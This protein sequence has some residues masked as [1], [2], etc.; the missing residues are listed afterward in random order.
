M[1][2]VECSKR[3]TGPMSIIWCTA[4]VSGMSAPASRA[5]RG[6]QTPQQMTTR[7]ASIVAARGLHRMD[8]AVLDHDV[9]HLGVGK[10]RQ[11]GVLGALAHDRGRPQRVDHT[12][13]GGVEATD[14]EALVD[15]GDELLDLRRE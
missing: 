2:V 3:G 12:G 1:N 6:L 15:V 9:R 10:H 13:A 8:A 11:A 14:D 7:S 4:G 5:M